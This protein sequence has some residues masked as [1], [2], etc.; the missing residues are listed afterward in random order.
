MRTVMAA[1]PASLAIA[2]I[3]VVSFGGLSYLSYHATRD[4]EAPAVGGWSVWLGPT[5]GAIESE[6]SEHL[7]RAVA[8]LA[9]AHGAETERTSRYGSEL[10]IA[11]RLLRRAVLASPVD[12]RAIERLA[13]VRWEQGVLTGSPDQ[14]AVASLIGL[15][16]TRAQRVPD[17]Q[18]ELGSTLYRMGRASEAEPFM[19]RAVVLSPSMTNRV[20]ATMAGAGVAPKAILQALSPLPDVLIAL[21]SPLCADGEGELFLDAVEQQLES[22]PDK[23]LIVYGEVALQ[24]DE[25]SRLRTRLIRL[26]PLP[27]AGAEA[28]R[29]HQLAHAEVVLGFKQEAYENAASAVA[30]G[31]S[32]PR[33][34]ELLGELAL[35]AGRTSDAEIV[36]REGLARLAT[37]D[38]SPHWRA[39]FYRGLGEVAERLGNGDVA[40]D[41]YKRACEQDPAEPVARQKLARLTEAVQFRDRKNP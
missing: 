31:P 28:E 14:T 38:G 1:Q 13:A 2:A 6:I 24:M 36:F 30:L 25:A 8:A 39:R 34:R 15:A 22:A 16:A 32:D 17:V 35:E 7:R 41:Q 9:G 26:G 40:F 21:R 23:L 37:S 5:S 20:V 3:F 11:D 12:T 10:G 27:F 19:T 29:R 4:V 33:Y 18:V